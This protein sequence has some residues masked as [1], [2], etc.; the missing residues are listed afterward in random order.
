MSI[1]LIA[2]LREGSGRAAE[3][4]GMAVIKSTTA[5]SDM[6]LILTIILCI[7]AS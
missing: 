3:K 2:A 5:M 4:D 6:S 1:S 7:I